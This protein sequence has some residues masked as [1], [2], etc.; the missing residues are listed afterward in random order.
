MRRDRSMCPSQARKRTS[1]ATTAFGTPAANAESVEDPAT[2]TSRASASPRAVASPILIDVKLPGPVPTT[3]PSMRRGSSTTSSIKNVSAAARSVQ[4]EPP[5]SPSKAHTAPTEVAQS[6][7]KIVCGLDRDTAMR[8]V[9]MCQGHRCAHRRKPGACV[10]GPLDKG[11]R[12]IEV[13]L[14]VA[15]VLRAEPADAVEVEMSHRNARR[16]AGPDRDR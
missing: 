11:N 6:K 7:D 13:R 9:D 8:F 2:G 12:A 1:S 16:V 14:E 4:P 10:L 3:M 5:S 15:P